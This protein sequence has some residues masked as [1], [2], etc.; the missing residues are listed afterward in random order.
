MEI[1]EGTTGYSRGD[2][3]QG[4][5]E[6]SVLP[7]AGGSARR[8]ASRLVGVALLGALV[9]GIGSA[10]LGSGEVSAMPAVFSQPQG[11][12]DQLPSATQTWNLGN[13]VILDSSRLVGT[14]EFGS[15]YWLLRS[16]S[17]PSQVCLLGRLESGMGGMSCTS[18][19]RFNSRGVGL[20]LEEGPALIEAKAVVNREL[21]VES[22]MYL[23][24]GA[25]VRN[26]PPGVTRDGQFLHT[27]GP[28]AIVAS[29]AL[30]F[31][32]EAELSR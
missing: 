22:A 23:P 5:R 10:V 18:L 1:S 30:Q 21:I 4:K 3:E 6:R 2:G 12:K 19:E 11:P 8:I 20:M 15:E 9:F 24:D 26:V 14:T 13:N 17:I 32:K 16:S 31:L 29:T 7:A 27:G 25:S 28:G